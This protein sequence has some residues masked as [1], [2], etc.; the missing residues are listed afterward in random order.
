M[1]PAVV[2]MRPLMELRPF[3]DDSPLYPAEAVDGRQPVDGA[4]AVDGRQPVDRAEAVD[5]GETQVVAPRLDVAGLLT[6]TDQAD[7]GSDRDADLDRPLSQRSHLDSPLR[8]PGRLRVSRWLCVA[9][10]LGVCR[11]SQGASSAVQ[12]KAVIGPTLFFRYSGSWGLGPGRP[13]PCVAPGATE[14]AVRRTRRQR[15]A[16][17]PKGKPPIRGGGPAVVRWEGRRG[18]RRPVS[19]HWTLNW[20]LVPGV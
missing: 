17:D 7:D 3:M 6:A 2:V 15:V 11:C 1:R 14:V 16:G 18:G 8:R 20:A 13:V 4:E 9:R 19:G 5:R 12:E 10:L